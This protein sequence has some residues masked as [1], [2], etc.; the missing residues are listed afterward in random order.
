LSTVVL[1][2]GFDVTA[3]D[4]TCTMVKKILEGGMKKQTTGRERF[5]E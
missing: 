3:Q 2:I 5:D 1:G 4:E